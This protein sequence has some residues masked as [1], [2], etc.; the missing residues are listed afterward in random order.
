MVAME[1][2]KALNAQAWQLNMASLEDKVGTWFLSKY[3]FASCNMPALLD[4]SQMQIQDANAFYRRVDQLVYVTTYE[5]WSRDQEMTGKVPCMLPN[6]GRGVD[7]GRYLFFIG[8]PM[9]GSG[10]NPWKGAKP[11]NFTD[12]VVKFLEMMQRRDTDPAQHSIKYLQSHPEVVD[13]PLKHALESR[14]DLQSWI[15]DYTCRAKE[16]S[17]DPFVKQLNSIRDLKAQCGTGNTPCKR[18][19]L[20]WKEYRELVLKSETK[21]GNVFGLLDT[22]EK[23]NAWVNEHI[24]DFVEPPKK[25]QS[26]LKEL[27]DKVQAQATSLFIKFKSNPK[28][29]L[30]GA[31]IAALTAVGAIVGVFALM[32]RSGDDEDYKSESGPG[33]HRWN[34]ETSWKKKKMP[35]RPAPNLQMQSGKPK[36]LVA[37]HENILNSL[38]SHVIYPNE[39]EI[40]VYGSKGQRRTGLANFVLGRI[41]T[42]SAH[43][44]DRQEKSGRI[45]LYKGDQKWEFNRDELAIV[46]SPNQDTCWVLIKNKQFH[47]HKNILHHFAEEKDLNLYMGTRLMFVTVLGEK[48][49][50]DYMRLPYE[51]DQVDYAGEDER[52]FCDRVIIGD[53]ASF[54]GQCGGFYIVEN[55]KWIRKIIAQHVS[56]NGTQAVGTIITQEM[57]KAAIEKLLRLESSNSDP[58]PQFASQSGSVHIKPFTREECQVNLPEVITNNVK[59]IGLAEPAHHIPSK[60]HI[61][62]SPLAPVFDGPLEFPAVLSQRTNPDGTKVDPKDNAFKKYN[63]QPEIKLEEWLLDQIAVFI[64]KKTPDLVPSTVLDLDEALNGVPGMWQLEPIKLRTSCGWPENEQRLGVGK[65]PFMERDESGR[66]VPKPAFVLDFDDYQKS[67]F[68]NW[69]YFKQQPE[70][71]TF[72]SN[73]KDERLPLRKIYE[74]RPDPEDPTNFQKWWIADTRTMDSTP[75]KLLLM[76]KMYFGAWLANLMTDPVNGYCSLGI[77]PHSADWLLLRRRLCKWGGKHLI[78]GDFKKYDISIPRK[79]HKYSTRSI[80]LWYIKSAAKRAGVKVALEKLLDDPRLMEILEEIKT[81]L[82][83]EDLARQRL[84]ELVHEAYHI[85]LNLLF[86]TKQGNPSGNYLTTGENSIVFTI[87]ALYCIKIADLLYSDGKMSLDEIWSNIEVASFGDDHVMAVSPKIARFFNC[88]IFKEIL[89]K[90]CGMTYT[91]VDKGDNLKDFYTIDEVTYLCRHFKMERDFCFSPLLKEIIEDMPNWVDTT[92]LEPRDCA[93]AVAVSCQM[94]SFHH[95][96]AYFN[97]VTSELEASLEA[98]GILDDVE[99]LDYDEIFTR[100]ADNQLSGI[101]RSGIRNDFVAQSGEPKSSPTREEQMEV[102]SP[103]A[104]QLTETVSFGDNVAHEIPALTQSEVVSTPSGKTDPYEN[105]GLTKV[106]QRNYVV[107]QLTWSGASATGTLIGTLDFPIL[108]TSIPFI[109]DKLKYFRYLRAGVR[110]TFRLNGTIMHFGSLMIVYCP[111]YNDTSTSANYA[112]TMYQASV[113]GPHLISANTNSTADIIIPYVAPERYF[114]MESSDIS[115]FFGKVWIY[116]LAPLRLV[117]DAS[118]PSLTL[119][120]NANFID[121]E[122]AGLGIRGA[123]LSNKPK[124]L[125]A[126]SGEANSKTVARSESSKYA[127]G[128][129]R[130]KVQSI[131]VPFSNAAMNIADLVEGAQGLFDKPRDLSVISRV[132]VNTFGTLAT[133]SGLDTSEIIAMDPE[134][135]IAYDT[136]LYCQKRDYNLFKNY[137]LL[138]GLLTT[139]SWT[140]ADTTGTKIL[141]LAVNPML[142]HSYN[143]TTTNFYEILPINNLADKFMFWRGGMKFHFVFYTQKFISGRISIKWIPTATVVASIGN[144]DFGNVASHVIDITGDTSYSFTVPYLKDKSWLFVPN[145]QLANT[146]PV[147]LETDQNFMNGQIIMEIL[148]P[149]SISDTL[150]EAACFFA[151]FISGASDFEVARPRTLWPGYSDG[152]S[153]PPLKKKV[154][155]EKLVAQSGSSRTASLSMDM[156]ALFE[157]PFPT[158]IPASTTVT[159]NVQMGEAVNSFTELAKRFTEVDTVSAASQTNWLFNVGVL[160]P[161][162]GDFGYFHRINRSFHYRRGSWRAKIALKCTSTTLW[163][164][165]Y[166]LQTGVA[167]NPQQV[168]D[169]ADGAVMQYMVNRNGIEFQVPY[170]CAFDM[171]CLTSFPVTE[172]KMSQGIQCQ[173]HSLTGGAITTCGAE[174]FASVGDDWSWGWPIPPPIVAQDL[175]TGDKQINSSGSPGVPPPVV[176]NGKEEEETLYVNINGELIPVKATDL[177]LK[178]KKGK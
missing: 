32:R 71:R 41:F 31:G 171:C 16:R 169:Y 93:R 151:V 33:M 135:S 34:W 141:T 142:C 52:I 73:L 4:A 119:T 104:T 144:E 86:Q 97:F 170:Y 40:I 67:F 162:T 103:Q 6:D 111:H 108:L 158:L 145:Y 7:T 78:A 45:E 149:L 82:G 131:T 76:Q 21:D 57:H 140:A 176:G 168:T 74:L 25:P 51:E 147:T 85:L 132:S 136:S 155:K 133:G 20:S 154:D 105:Q 79:V 77:N 9:V 50:V 14:P 120:I 5:Q 39:Y 164:R 129:L 30:I 167:D 12:F 53:M 65:T 84:D 177:V 70:N 47:L 156:R 17:I 69:N 160:Y 44:L 125:K 98:A 152:T 26:T 46:F 178:Q 118:T 8:N 63:I 38:V 150:S 90:H 146:Q 173:V 114:D 58:K 166:H 42:T 96:E 43:I 48:I 18:C 161:T 134:N 95:G 19:F 87:L 102:T 60:S 10:V 92:N 61:E 123:S 148:N 3:V 94:E 1:I 68:N 127:K 13:T 117:G 56:G 59:I 138:P 91:P 64:A 49:F 109:E 172:Q 113:L 36:N 100:F 89:F 122:V 143:V 116:V 115:G 27:V 29:T 66:I 106:L 28:T 72:C 124:N 23:Y 174:I 88:L 112:E 80:R 62:L 107:S 99:L 165:A 139:G 22:E 130:K 137:K 35:K 37:Q 2:V 24:R 121:P 153:V 175:S 75:L 159:K 163:F 101:A 83:K 157:Q 11:L 128:S 55:S 126:Q 54:G 81:N 15:S 110:V